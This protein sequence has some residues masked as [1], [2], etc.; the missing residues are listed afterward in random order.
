MPVMRT[1]WLR[2]CPP[3]KR[4][5]LSLLGVTV[6]TAAVSAYLGRG[7]LEDSWWIWR[8]GSSDRVT[9]IE[10]AQKLAERKC[11]RAVPRIVSL[12]GEDPGE[13]I[14][15]V[16]TWGRG[17]IGETVYE[18]KEDRYR[19]ATPLVLALWTIG[20]EAIPAIERAQ[21]DLR[22]RIRGRPPGETGR[23]FLVLSI[24]DDLQDRSTR[25]EP[26]HRARWIRL[27]PQGG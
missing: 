12:I 22:T 4:A 13:K 27:G 9:R 10:A 2:R 17:T 3:G 25:M 6:A 24:L 19:T 20:E 14:R 26:Q 1:T 5:A 7:H 18:K 8:L 15:T 16:T 21:H 11:L 23:A